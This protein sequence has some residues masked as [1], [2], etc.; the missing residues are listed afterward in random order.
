MENIAWQ[1]IKD[2]ITYPKGGIVSQ[3]ISKTK[4]SQVTLFCM[5]AG[6]DISEHTSAKEGFVFIIEGKGTFDLGKNRIEM[7]PGTLIT[8]KK[9]AVHSIAASENTAFILVLH[10]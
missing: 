3:V 7:L 6:T 5:S 8:M 9:S 4:K 1:N 10:E 2:K